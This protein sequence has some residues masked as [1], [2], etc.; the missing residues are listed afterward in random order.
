MTQPPAGLET[1][2]ELD[3]SVFEQEAGFWI[4]IEAKKVTPSVAIPHGIKYSLTLHDRKGARVLGYDN[5]HGLDP[6]GKRFK[7]RRLVYDHK[8]RTATDK[9]VSYSFATPQ[10][11]LQDFFA[12]CDRVIGP[13]KE[14]G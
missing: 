13:A 2:L 12:E 7:G 1:L 3:G 11:L 5:A 8:H 4:K 14:P 9:G 6:S 10:Q